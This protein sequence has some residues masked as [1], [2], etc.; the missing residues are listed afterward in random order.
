[1]NLSSTDRFSSLKKHS[2]KWAAFLRT[3]VQEPGHWQGKEIPRL[4]EMLFSVSF[5][6]VL[7]AHSI[8]LPLSPTIKGKSNKEVERL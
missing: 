8:Y 2:A 5:F 4:A 1:M 3:V 7:S 6:F